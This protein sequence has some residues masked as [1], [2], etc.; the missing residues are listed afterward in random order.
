MKHVIIVILSA[1]VISVG[2][3]AGKNP[4][5]GPINLKKH[6]LPPIVRLHDLSTQSFFCS[7]HVVAQNMIVTAA[8]C[9]SNLQ[10]NAPVLIMSPYD[11]SK[12]RMAFVASYEGQS[13]QALVTGD[14]TDFD[15]FPIATDA[16]TI[17]N[18]LENPKTRL[19]SCGFPHAGNLLCTPMQIVGR[20]GFQVEVNGFMY[21]GMSGGPVIDLNTGYQI[22][23]NTAVAGPNALISPLVEM[24]SNLNVKRPPGVN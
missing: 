23:V 8:H 14:F 22:G 1:I 15:T 12:F 17:I 20:Y 10:L 4:T 24:W 9:L 13:D 19:I 3:V 6:K 5:I 16:K 18:I 11:Y 21:R 2:L 7:G